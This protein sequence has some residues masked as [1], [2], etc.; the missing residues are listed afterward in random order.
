MTNRTIHGGGLGMPDM[1]RRTLLSGAAV[2]GLGVLGVACSSPSDSAGPSGSAGASSTGNVSDSDA[3]RKI[4]KDTA[5]L[6]TTPGAVMLYRSPDGTLT[7]TYGS[8]TTAGKTPVTVKDHFRVGSVTKTFTGTV[9]LQLAQEGKLTLEDPVAK[10]RPEVPNGAN[11]TVAQLLSMR[12]G[13]YNYTE[14]LE[15][16]Q[17]LDADP[18]R[19]WTIDELLAIAFAQ[20]PYFAPG[21]GYHYSNT[22]IVLLGLIAQTLDERELAESY[23]KRLFDPLGMSETSFPPSDDDAIP[24]PHP[25]GYMY[26]TN[27]STMDSAELSEADQKAAAAG[28]L[29]PNDVTNSSPSWT[30]AAGGAISTLEDLATWVTAMGDGSLLD[31]TWQDK[32]MSSVQSVDPANPAAPGYGLAIAQFGPMFGHT[33]EMPGFQAFTGYDPDTKR[34]LVVLSNL[35]S[36]PDGRPVSAT[37]AQGLIA[38]MYK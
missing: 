33:G 24:D 11:I 12:S 30:W 19:V 32:R 34:T 23:Q 3:L 35:N 27:V 7:D 38:E 20:P 25:H 21:Q 37:I 14:A 5:K 17:S 36:G 16:N 13:L 4:F 6:M 8:R 31:A 2:L 22:G 1:S 15:F 26:G 10:Y 9:I 29:K 28:T 18:K